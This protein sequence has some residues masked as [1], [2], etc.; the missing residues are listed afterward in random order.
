MVKAVL[1][2]LDGTLID[3]AP[4]LA[5]ALNILRAEQ[6]LPTLPFQEIRPYASHGTVGLLKIG[7]DLE[8][9]SAEFPVL[10]ARFLEVYYQNLC[11]QT[12]PFPHL[13][14]VLSNLRHRDI[15]WGIVTNKPRGLTTPLL[16]QFDLNPPNNCLV[17]GDSTPYSKPHPAPL[18]EAA[19]LLKIP[20]AECLYVG[21]AER[22]IIAGTAA[23][24]KTLI[25]LYGYIH[26]N[27]EPATWGATGTIQ[28]LA[29]LVNWLS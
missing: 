23:G 28:S 4:D 11:R 19:S 2:D 26:P 5:W 7:F 17:C 10:R 1:F 15:A 16:A 29:E 22:D 25:A 27:E 24:M 18:L 12:T 14:S 13:E 9:H 3:T 20:P 8:A 6:N 21:D